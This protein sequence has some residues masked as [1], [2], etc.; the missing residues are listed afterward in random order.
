MVGENQD[1]PLLSVQ[2]RTALSLGRWNVTCAYERK[3]H[4]RSEG[5]FDKQPSISNQRVRL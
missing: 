3:R 1:A 4:E 5:Q 2:A